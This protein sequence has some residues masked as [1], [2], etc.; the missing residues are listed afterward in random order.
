MFF[1]NNKTYMEVEIVEQTKIIPYILMKYIN[2]QTGEIKIDIPQEIKKIVLVASGS[3]YHCARFAVDLVEKISKI[4]SRAIY[5]SEFL[6]KSIIPNDENTLYIF[7]TQSGETSDTIKAAERVKK[8]TNLPIL[9]I[10][11]KEESTIWNMCDYKI[12]CFAGEE[13]GIAATKSF[14]SQMLCLILLSLKLIEN[15]GQKEVTKQ[16]KDSLFH[17]P[18][19]MEKAIAKRKDIKSFAKHLAKQDIVVITADGISYSLAK[20]GA[21]KIKETSY[22]NI[23]AAILGEFMHG[24]VA[25]LNNKKSTVIFISVDKISER[26]VNNLNKI[27]TDY[28]PYLTVIGVNNNSVNTNF[29]INV[30]CENVIQQLFANVIILQLLA[31]ETALKLK[32]NVDNPKGLHKVVTDSAI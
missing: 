14:T 6:L 18:A 31:L 23:S 28:N 2:P 21:L 3:S 5:S 29:Q 10:T 9:C 22:K 25:V 19:I 12:A 20:E 1:K 30:E 13:H 24:H 7:I 15:S 8:E 17:I 4:E 26:S 16:Y 27:K 32:R 11:N